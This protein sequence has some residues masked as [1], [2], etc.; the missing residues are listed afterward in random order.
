MTP[1]PYQWINPF[2]LEDSAWLN[3]ARES[4]KQERQAWERCHEERVRLA[5]R[6]RELEAQAQPHQDTSGANGRG[7]GRP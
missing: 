6:V 7:P 3:L 2:S 4:L 1:S 5:E